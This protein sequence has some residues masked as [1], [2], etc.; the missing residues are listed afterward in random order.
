MRARNGRKMPSI[1]FSYSF[2]FALARAPVPKIALL[3]AGE[4]VQRLRATPAKKQRPTIL[5]TPSTRYQIA[6]LFLAPHFLFCWGSFSFSKGFYAV[7]AMHSLLFERRFAVIEAAWSYYAQLPADEVPRKNLQ[8]PVI[9]GAE[10]PNC[11]ASA[12]IWVR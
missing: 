11:V 12:R 3:R 4:A 7:S 10:Y 8:A 1:S 6:C 5:K 9:G 2:S